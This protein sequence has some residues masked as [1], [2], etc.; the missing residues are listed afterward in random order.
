VALALRE[1]H[2]AQWRPESVQNLLVNRT[3]MWA[4]LRGDPLERLLAWGESERASFLNRRASY[5]IYR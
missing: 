1:R 4:F 3:T 5:L 2:R